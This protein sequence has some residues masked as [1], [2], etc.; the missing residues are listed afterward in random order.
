MAPRERV[1]ATLAAEAAVDGQAHVAR[2]ATPGDARRPIDRA[3]AGAPRTRGPAAGTAYGLR[4]LGVRTGRAGGVRLRGG[5]RRGRRPGA[6]PALL[7]G[8]AALLRRD[9]SRGVSHPAPRS[10]PL[11][12]TPCLR[13]LGWGAAQRRLRQSQSRRRPDPGRPQPPRA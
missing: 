4:A 2:I 9:V 1:A 8:A 6:F 11:G 3:P 13:V 12:A 10:L 7:S 5:C